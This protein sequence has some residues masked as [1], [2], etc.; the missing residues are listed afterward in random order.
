MPSKALP[1]APAAFQQWCRARAL[2]PS[3]C[4]Y[5]S[6]IRSSQPVRRV[7]SRANNVS[8]TYPSDKMGVAVQFESHKVELWAIL[9]MDRDPDVLEFYDQPHTFKLRYLRKSGKQMQSH[10]YTSDFLVLRRNDVAFE[11]WKTED[12]L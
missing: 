11:E 10:S 9:V 4:D 6:T 8:G 7:T 5:L 1:M 2:A 12:E 3:T